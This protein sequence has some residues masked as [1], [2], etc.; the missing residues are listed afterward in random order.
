MGFFP[1]LE[2]S[3]HLSMKHSSVLV[4]RS[5]EIT[6]TYRWPTIF[7]YV[8]EWTEILWCSINLWELPGNDC[9][10]QKVWMRFQIWRLQVVPIH[11]NQNELPDHWEFSIPRMNFLACYKRDFV[12][13][14]RNAYDDTVP[15]SVPW[16][17]L[18]SSSKPW[19]LQTDRGNS[20]VFAEVG[21]QN[22]KSFIAQVKLIPCP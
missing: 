15:G 5:P 19:N 1:F 8:I 9:E 16:P 2:P 21:K 6:L 22:S 17:F 7:W 3:L 11:R 18:I 10:M 14:V 12:H 20:V 13:R 4:T